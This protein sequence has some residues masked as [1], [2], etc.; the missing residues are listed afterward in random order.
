MQWPSGSLSACEQ[1]SDQR[2]HRKDQQ[3]VDEETRDM[4]CKE[5]DY[6]EN[7]KNHRDPKKH[8]SPAFLLLNLWLA[9]RITAETRRC[10]ES[11]LRAVALLASSRNS[12]HAMR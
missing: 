5:Q 1:M 8:L 6:P 4:N 12:S 10:N 11:Q 9:R 2:N 7:C 3:N